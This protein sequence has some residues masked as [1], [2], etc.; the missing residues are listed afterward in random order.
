MRR[1][2]NRPRWSGTL[3]LFVHFALVWKTVDVQVLSL[4]ERPAER[5]ERLNHQ[6]VGIPK[7]QHSKEQRREMRSPLHKDGRTHRQKRHRRQTSAWCQKVHEADDQL[8][9]GWMTLGPNFKLGP[10]HFSKSRSSSRLSPMDCRRL[11]SF[12]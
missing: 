1:C 12:S 11:V 8:E 7:S 6:L 10:E 3:V 2:K 4:P 9:P 5:E